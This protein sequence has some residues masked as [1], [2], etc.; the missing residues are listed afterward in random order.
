[1]ANIAQING[2]Y[3]DSGTIPA[4]VKGTLYCSASSTNN[5]AIDGSGSAKT[6]AYT[7]PASTEF[8]LHALW[9]VF[10]GT[11][12]GFNKSGIGNITGITS[13]T[14]ITLKAKDDYETFHDFLSGLD[15]SDF[16]GWNFAIDAA[17][18]EINRIDFDTGQVKWNHWNLFS[19]YTG[20]LLDSNTRT[21]PKIEMVV[22]ANLSTMAGGYV[23]FLGANY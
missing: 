18:R 20:L 23:Y 21:N 4:I 11:A 15:Y 19:D 7:I 13:T 17:S 6:F 16:S 10:I 9:L 14:A 22:S 3:Q 12:G 1:M 8:R 5:F 2:I